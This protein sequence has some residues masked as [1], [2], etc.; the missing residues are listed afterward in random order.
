MIKFRPPCQRLIHKP[1]TEKFFLFYILYLQV[2][3]NV[4]RVVSGRTWAEFR[5]P[6]P[7]PVRKIAQC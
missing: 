2:L 5:T 6:L 7:V 4:I 3:S 1:V